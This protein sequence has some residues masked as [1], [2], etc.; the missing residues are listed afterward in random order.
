M[1]V[2]A[3]LG[4][5]LR[6]VAIFILLQTLP[7]PR[8]GDFAA[9]VMLFAL[10]VLAPAIANGL[11]LNQ[12]LVAFYPQPSTPIWLSPAVAWAEA[13]AVASLTVGRLAIGARRAAVATA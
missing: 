13:I 4:F 8:R 6:D 11:G 12:T 1:F 3:A 2:G 7:G 10:Y 5:L 9:V